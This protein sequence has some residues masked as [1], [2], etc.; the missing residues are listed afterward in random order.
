MKYPLC[1]MVHQDGAGSVGTVE[2]SPVAESHVLRKFNPSLDAGDAVGKTVDITK[3]LCAALVQQM[4]DLRET[5]TATAGQKRGASIAITAIEGAQ[6][7]A[8]K[9]NFAQA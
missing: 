8:V 2:V 4:I 5:P 7:A 9:A 6:M 1:V 3:A